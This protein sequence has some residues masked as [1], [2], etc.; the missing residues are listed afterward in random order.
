MSHTMCRLCGAPITT[1]FVETILQR[2]AVQFQHCSRCDYM[3]TE[4]PHWLDEAYARPITLQDTGLLRRNSTLS[5]ILALYLFDAKLQDGTFL[6]YAGG[7]GV[8]TRLMRDMGFDYRWSD[9]FT[10]NLFAVGFEA[11]LDRRFDAISAIEVVEHLV[12]PL[13]EIRKLLEHTDT[14]FLSTELRPSRIPDKDWTYYGFVH[15]QH[16]GFFS[17]ESLRYIAEQTETRLLTDRHSVH[18]FTRLGRPSR[19]RRF[20]RI[21]RVRSWLVR[22]QRMSF[23]ISDSRSLE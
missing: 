13:A 16:V 5:R 23:T 18:T 8:M 2:H 9:P 22:R 6:D 10:T 11:D 12:N 17:Q 21:A 15:G 20:G 1:A 4:E 3:Q 7:Y 14:L 19:L